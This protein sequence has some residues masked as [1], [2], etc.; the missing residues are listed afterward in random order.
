MALPLPYGRRPPR[1]SEPC[2][3][4]DWS[5]RRD[6][7]STA[8]TASAPVIGW[9]AQQVARC[10]RKNVADLC[11]GYVNAQEWVDGVAIGMENMA[12]LHDNIEIFSR[13]ALTDE[14]AANIDMTRPRL[15][16]AT[17]NPALWGNKR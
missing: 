14:Q 15:S 11:L 2:A 1:G 16:E 17:L 3:A 6:N 4:P 7:R 9:L 8:S 5:T 12:Q 13:L 10:R